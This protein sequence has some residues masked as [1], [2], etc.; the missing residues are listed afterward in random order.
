MNHTLYHLD[1][2]IELAR[3]SYPGIV[4]QLEATRATMVRMTY[5]SAEDRAIDA[6]NKALR[7]SK[8]TGPT[9]SMFAEYRE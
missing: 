1:N 9:P 3:T 4:W 2:A 5:K 7:L 6:T 8:Q